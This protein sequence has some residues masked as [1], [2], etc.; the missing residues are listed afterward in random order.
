MQGARLAG[1]QSTAFPDA[2]RESLPLPTPILYR[3]SWTLEAC[4]ANGSNFG[5]SWLILT[6]RIGSGIS[7]EID[8][9]LD[10]S[11]TAFPRRIN[12]RGLR[13]EGPPQSREGVGLD[14]RPDMRKSKEQQL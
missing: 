4:R 11:V 14:S 3:K 9:P 7:Q 5:L 13:R 6:V 8:V 12:R 1:Q 2:Y 10:G